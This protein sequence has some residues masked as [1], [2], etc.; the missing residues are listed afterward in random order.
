MR[1]SVMETRIVR[2]PQQ[3]TSRYYLDANEK[4]ETEEERKD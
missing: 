1:L 3:E 2:N 4:E